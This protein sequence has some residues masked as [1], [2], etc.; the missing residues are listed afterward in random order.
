M[1]ENFIFLAL[2]VATVWQCL[3]FMAIIIAFLTSRKTKDSP[4]QNPV[5]VVVA[6]RNEIKTLPALIERL[7]AQRYPDYEVIIVNDRSSDGSYEFLKETEKEQPHFT[8]VNID[9]KPENFDG[10]KYALTLGIKA[11]KHDIIVL[12]DADCRPRSEDWLG[13]MANG[14]GD[15]NIKIN[16]GVSLYAGGKGIL[17]RF[18]QFEALWTAAQYIGFALLGM[19]YM[20]VGR[21]LAYKKAFFLRRKGFGNFMSFTGGDDDLFVNQNGTG[22]NTTVTLGRESMVDSIPKTSLRAFFNQKI[23]HL[24]VGR[25]YKGVHRLLL[26]S[27]SATSLVFWGLLPA[28][29]FLPGDMVFCIILLMLRTLLLC[30]TF[31]I[32]TKKTGTSFHYWTLPFLD[33]IFTGYYFYA[34]MAVLLTKRIRWN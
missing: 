31:L 4:V 15:D 2:L 5:S 24:S 11:A 14:F 3:Y 9:R 28:S 17:G 19:P 16:L 7:M 22:K 10:K 27:Y 30:I 25:R 33:I 13:S 32:T 26:G 20:G 34:G 6:A 29:M 8:V 23:R 12:T 18:I 1:I 21:N